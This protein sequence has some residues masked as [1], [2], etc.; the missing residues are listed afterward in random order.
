MVSEIYPMAH[1]TWK[2]AY[3]GQSQSGSIQRQEPC[4]DSA[5]TTPLPLSTAVQAARAKK[6]TQPPSCP[7]SKFQL[8]EIASFTSPA[9]QLVYSAHFLE[10]VECIEPEGHVP[11]CHFFA[12]KT[13]P[14]L[15]NPVEGNLEAVMPKWPKT[16]ASETMGKG[17]MYYLQ[18]MLWFY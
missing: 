17:V 18:A 5:N 13:L 16:H 15:Q 6:C 12:R 7:V 1:L 11:D 9:F 10:L 8:G 14:V 4:S 2:R 3:I